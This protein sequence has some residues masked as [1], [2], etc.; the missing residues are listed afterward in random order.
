MYNNQSLISVGHPFVQ[1]SPSQ[2]CSNHIS[3]N[4]SRQDR[5]EQSHDVCARH[6]RFLWSM[7]KRGINDFNFYPPEKYWLCWDVLQSGLFACSFSCMKCWA[8]LKRSVVCGALRAAAV[9]CYQVVIMR[10]QPD[11]APHPVRAFKAFVHVVKHATLL[12]Q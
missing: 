4:K 11:A 5:Q 3:Q 2:P 10:T 7:I 1:E 8:S 6:V 12:F 9:I